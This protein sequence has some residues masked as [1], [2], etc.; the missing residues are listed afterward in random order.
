M[1]NKSLL[2]EDDV[3]E[4]SACESVNQVLS[5]TGVETPTFDEV[6]KKEKK[7]QKIDR[8]KVKPPVKSQ[9]S[10]KVNIIQPTT[11]TDESDIIL[12]SLF[13]SRK[14][15]TDLDS[16]LMSTSAASS[17]KFFKTKFRQ[18]FGSSISSWTNSLLHGGKK[19]KMRNM[20]IK[21]TKPVGTVGR[22]RHTIGGG[23]QQED[24]YSTLTI[25]P[26]VEAGGLGMKKNAKTKKNPKSSLAPGK[27]NQCSLFSDDDDDRE[28]LVSESIGLFRTGKS[29]SSKPC[30]QNKGIVSKR[31]PNSILEESEAFCSPPV[32]DPSMI[33]S[34]IDHLV[35]ER[36]GVQDFG[37]TV[38][39]CTTRVLEML[40]WRGRPGPRHTERCGGRSG[41]LRKEW[42]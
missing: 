25:S 15:S 13:F 16:S 8:N 22:P 24:P 4:S 7:R 27:S 39:L 36:N 26:V 17:K 40:A 10:S 28:V 41:G 1:S 6:Y 38:L 33:N 31:K 18:S 37:E 3:T 35:A 9:A 30:V 34:N 29:F 23:C 20:Y 14:P 32:L 19:K 42:K 21:S 5:C 11:S 2:L 12:P